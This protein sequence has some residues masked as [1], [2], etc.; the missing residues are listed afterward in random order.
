MSNFSFS[1]SVFQRPV[2][3]KFN[4]KGVFDMVKQLILYG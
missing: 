4:N 3:Q 1:H 2:L